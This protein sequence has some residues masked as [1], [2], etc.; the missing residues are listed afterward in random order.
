MKSISILAWNANGLI[1]HKNELQVILELNNIDLCL[2]SETHMTNE[3]YCKMKGYKFYHTLHPSNNARGGSGVFVKEHLKHYENIK[4][5]SESIQLASVTI[6]TMQAPIT[7]ASIY[8]P[9]GK[10]LTK[11]N[12]NPLFKELGGRFIIGGDFNAK[13][14]HWGS[15][16]TTDRGRTLFK[17]IKENKGEFVSTGKPTYWPTDP[18]K[19]PDLIDFFIYKN[20][21]ANYMMIDENLELC[22]DHS[23]IV[24]TISENIIFKTNNPVLVNKK[25]DWDSFRINLSERLVLNHVLKSKEDIDQAVEELVHS[26]QISSWDNTP[27]TL[28]KSHGTNYPKEIVNLIKEK[29]K[30]RKK[31][32]NFRYPPYKTAYNKL[33][34]KVRREIKNLKNESIQNYLSELSPDRNSDYSLWRAIKPLKR[35]ILQSPPLKNLEGYWIRDNQAKCTAFS[36]YL[37]NVFTPN[38]PDPDALPLVDISYQEE[39]YLIPKVTVREVQRTIK[40]EIN[41]KKAPGYDLITGQVLKELPRKACV[42]ISQI[43]NAAF[44]IQYVPQLWKVAEVIM[45]IKPGQKPEDPKSYRPISLLPV[46][47]KLFEKVLHKRLIC[48]IS[49]KKLI[50]DH[51]FGFRS[52][53]STTEQVHRLVHLIE[54]SLEEKKVCSAVFL[55]VTKAFDKVWHEGLKHK[56]KQLLP[57]KLVKLLESYLSN[58]YFRIKQEEAYSELV[59]IRAGV[60]QGS[61]LG[62]ILYL[63]YV[64]DMPKEEKNMTATFAD[65]TAFLAVGQTTQ[66]TATELNLTLSRFQRW[67]IQWRIRLNE[68]KSVHVDFTNKNQPYIPTYINHEVIPF[69]NQAKYLGMTLDTKLKW[70]EHVKKKREQLELKYKKMKWLMGRY[71]SLSIENKSLLYN[72]VLKPVWTY[73]IQLWGC[74]SASNRLQIERFQNKVLRDIANAPWYIRND[75]LHRDLGVESIKDT[76]KRYASAHQ[77][78]LQAHD[79]IEVQVHLLEES[80]LVRRLKR[81]KP[82]E[83]V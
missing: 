71:S 49:S 5:Q 66:E 57:E 44:K 11:E 47:S 13:H 79:N 81:R 6:Q 25:T 54:K 21:S 48:I 30:A 19:T 63:L 39:E 68:A 58:R 28:T 38:E 9:P 83:L 76:M 52:K 50:P 67:T 32:Q 29:R 61:V 14:I 40:E 1:P 23:A 22:S 15:R 4:F 74:T 17:I 53:H 43:I 73:G 60:P 42:K 24:L 70:K 56:L 33:A 7:V 65:D 8:C 45:I 78:R 26:I 59:E 35:P 16:M 37:S 77:E 31:W 46:L 34:E 2:I 69:S 55:D 64:N 41:P 36:E 75:M 27:I 3:Q 51:Q 10:K 62:P 82:F 12:L 20:I 72:Q 80:S 18:N